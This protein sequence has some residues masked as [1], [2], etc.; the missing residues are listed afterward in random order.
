MESRQDASRA[1]R[2]HSTEAGCTWA[3]VTRA[4]VDPRGTV[5]L[6]EVLGSTLDHL[7]ALA[8]PSGHRLP[9]FFFFGHCTL[10]KET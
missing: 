10:R 5:A 9:Y 2:A 7:I 1:S 3:C 8:A 6:P 4:H